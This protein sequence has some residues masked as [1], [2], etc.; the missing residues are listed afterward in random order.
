M[1]VGLLNTHTHRSR[2]SCVAELSAPLQ[3]VGKFPS[4]QDKSES[5]AV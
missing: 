2:T 5:E 1:L 4:L 3:A